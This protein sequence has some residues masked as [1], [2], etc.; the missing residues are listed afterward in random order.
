MARL[1]FLALATTLLTAQVVFA[2]PIQAPALALSTQLFHK[3]VQPLNE[4]VIVPI[5]EALVPVFDGIDK[6]WVSRPEPTSTI[7]EMTGTL[8]ERQITLPSLPTVN[9][10]GPDTSDG[11]IGDFLFNLTYPVLGTLL[12]RWVFERR[13]VHA[14]GTEVNLSSRSP[15]ILMHR[16]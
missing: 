11:P 3:S 15:G 6:S 8:K 5:N 4:Q 2:A 16:G 14:L 12:P 13:W 7:S 9:L 10:N 1:R